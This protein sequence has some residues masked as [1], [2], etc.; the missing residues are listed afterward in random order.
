MRGISVLVAGAGLAGLSAARALT[1]RGARV[2]AIDARSRV[3]G[4]VQTSREPFRYRQHAELGGDLIDESHTE[5]CRLAAELGLEIARILP[6]SFAAVTDHAGR[7]RIAGHRG[8]SD[9]AKALRPE[10]RALCLAEQRWDS[11][12]AAALAREPVAH[13]LDRIHASRPLRDVATGLRGFFLADPDELSLLALVDQFADDGAP[14]GER[15]FRIVGGNDRL[16]A[17]LAKGLGSRIQ[18]RSVLRRVTLSA[19]SVNASIE[20]HGR[21]QEARFDAVVCTLPATTLRDVVFEPALPEEQW[22]AITM[23]K[24]G[25]ATKTALQFDRASWRKRGSP[26]AFGTALPIGAVWDGS[27]EQHAAGRPRGRAHP[28]ILS[29]LAG[30]TASTAT[31]RMLEQGGPPQIVREMSWLDLSRATLLGWT[32]CSWELEDWS[33]GGY[34]YFDTG[35]PPS[36]RY[37]LA[38]PS[39]RLFFA[40]EHTSLRWQ[41]YMNGAV[42]TG[43]R[44]AE[45]ALANLESRI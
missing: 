33:R 3:G 45:E 25:L 20:A 11:G 35:F 40:G 23:V 37:A 30:G 5:I 38:R 2:L 36:L 9:L 4:R 15:M 22:R 32:S 41:G 31:R 42:E 7:R 6:G 14:G 12:V 21:L 43:L 16:P 44:A 39:P 8:W 18:L 26:R 29:L 27:E 28:G 24:Y 17:A 13:W 10:V 34:A 1:Q 19:D